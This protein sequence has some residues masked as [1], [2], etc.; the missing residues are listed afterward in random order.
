MLAS[1][2]TILVSLFHSQ[3]KFPL[4]PL[5]NFQGKGLQFLK[6]VYISQF[7]SFLKKVEI[8]SM[9]MR[10]IFFLSTVKLLIG[11][12]LVRTSTTSPFNYTMLDLRIQKRSSVTQLS[13]FLLLVFLIKFVI[14][15]NSQFPS[16]LYK[17][18]FSR[19]L[20]ISNHSLANIGYS[21]IP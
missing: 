6:V 18:L 20:L 8:I 14:Y 9:S 1:Q 2:W 7:P 11:T 17:C 19:I 4:G 13:L 12:P 5:R 10:F 15:L 3:W 21:F 16:N